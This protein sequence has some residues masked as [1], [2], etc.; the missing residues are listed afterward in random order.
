MDLL[1]KMHI[2]REKQ[3]KREGVEMFRVLP[4]AT[5]QA[6][7][8]AC[9]KTR[10]EFLSVRG[11][12]EGKWRKYGPDLQK[13][14][15]SVEREG[16]DIETSEALGE[17][18][19]EVGEGYQSDRSDIFTVGEYL[20]AV[21]A[22]I[23]PMS[24]R[25]RGEIG[26]V[27]DRGNYA[28]FSLKSEEGGEK[29]IM[30]CFMWKRDAALC[31]VDLR[32]G[33]EVLVRGYPEIYR[34][35][36]RF[37]FRSDLVELVGEGALKLAYEKLKSKLE[38]EGLFSPERK[39]AIPEFPRTIGLITS[40]DGAVI[41][42]FLNN[43]A[44][45][46]FRVRFISSRVE[47]QAAVKSLIGA[48]KRFRRESV[49]VV[50]LIRGGGSPESLQAFNNESLIREIV[51]MP[52]PVL[53]GIGHHE[54]V[55]LATLAADVAVSTPTAAAVALNRSWE[56]AAR[57]VARY[58]SH[59]LSSFASVFE[60][61]RRRLAVAVGVQVGFLDD[62]QRRMDRTFGEFLI[63]MERYSQN[64]FQVGGIIPKLAKRLRAGFMRISRDFESKVS[65]IWKHLALWNP[66]SVLKRG[67][68]IVTRR[69]KIVRSAKEC[70]EG[71]IID[72][73]FA[74]G[75]V[76][77]MVRPDKSGKSVMAKKTADRSQ[78]RT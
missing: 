3:A 16:E 23:G 57:I 29:N 27:N 54:D 36:G 62:T 64:L 30:N 24:A 46:G 49:D 9:P 25:V 8:H 26:D 10:S 56:D 32:D 18:G 63:R 53:C 71:D 77:A 5:L 68:A 7:C 12:K 70:R 61:T 21:N 78:R 6:L 43:L 4:S 47:G 40:K 20:S 15:S 51:G 48:L 31:G 35:T 76:P 2:W 42:D 58:Q 44:S 1:E 74:D 14:F 22:T 50:V 65:A 19:D 60:R 69:G 67:Y 41:H 33:L 52:V 55:P 38:G 34:P 73:M 28:F 45:F 11:F 13:I 66:R 72:V 59:F 75:A 39:R 37:V 17:R